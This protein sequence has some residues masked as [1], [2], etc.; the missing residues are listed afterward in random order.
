MLPVWSE[1]SGS[2]MYGYVIVNICAIEQS[3]SLLIILVYVLTIVIQGKI[4]RRVQ[5]PF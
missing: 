2:I 3:N 4:F 5:F 1:H